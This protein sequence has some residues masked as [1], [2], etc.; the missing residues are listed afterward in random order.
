MEPK[1]APESAPLDRWRP[2]D[3]IE[4]GLRRIG[5]NDHT[6][7]L[8]LAAAVGLIAGGGVVLFRLGYE[9]L[10]ALFVPGA[11]GHDL[12]EAVRDRPAVAL[13][14]ATALG[15]LVVGLI[16]RFGLRGH[17]FHG[18]AQ[19]IHAVAYRE[20]RIPA[21]HT[22]VR[23]V[24]NALSI[25]AGGSVGP[26][27]P[28]IELGSGV[29]STAAQ[30]LRLSP[31]RIRTLVG[32]G[33]AAGLSA[34]FNAPIAGAF[35]A[36]ELVLKDFA[37]VTFSP[38]IVASVTA[39]ALSRMVLGDAPAFAVPAYEPGAITEMPFYVVLG[40]LAGV[41]GTLFTHALRR[42]ERVV[43]TWP[44]PAWVKPAVGGAVLGGGLVLL[45]DLYGV[46]YEPINELLGGELGVGMLLVLLLAKF[47]A[48]N[49]TLASGFAGG[50]FAP[51][52]FM[53]GAL[54]GA[55]GQGVQ[56][57]IGNSAA[58][59]GAYALVG[60]AAVMAAVTHAPITAILLLFEMT[61][62]Y[63][64]ILPL[65]LACI[66]AVA[67]AQALSRDSAFTLGLREQGLDVNYGRESAILRNFYVEDVMH[68]DVPVVDVRTRFGE[69]LDG[70]LENEIDRWYVVDGNEQLVGTID[71]HGIKSVLSQQGLRWVVIAADV[72]KPVD[73]AVLRRENLEEA[74]VAFGSAEDEEVPVLQG[75]EDR[76]VVGRLS[77]GDV[78]DLY[79]R[80]ILRK[81]VLGVKLVQRDEGV[82]DFVDL[83]SEYVVRSIALQD[84][85][86]GRTLAELKL[87]ERSGVHV[88]A[89]K[90]PGRRLAGRNELP[91][92]YA[93]LQ[94]RDRLV[95]VGHA[96]AL[97]T[98]DRDSPN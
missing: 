57:L 29:G 30:T 17:G 60:M 84:D 28:V 62:G 56:A 24:T 90:H 53:G 49:V 44:G 71:L 78:L 6:L 33:A 10:T 68:D 93:P 80:E 4:A 98:I 5:L 94:R 77:R 12:V 51:I 82:T 35:F 40:V 48:T 18:V 76:R 23:F 45:P 42:S 74:I 95:V 97:D 21:R 58:P 73:T 39:T 9:A 96:D 31:E 16:H 66:A 36:L 34:A 91:D 64:V 3:L 19:V 89:V 83:P 85:W 75:P 13:I 50:I 37:V 26:E 79:N 54:G 46:G 8:I 69:L 38:I 52:L 72:M 11:H 87:R 70:F 41:L 2:L 63:A 1:R 86:V 47:L 81:D 20:G 61:G 65:M 27:G 25:A 92:P 67:V 14:G 7:L 15:G 88:L 22:A 59:T 32:C 43:A 55:V